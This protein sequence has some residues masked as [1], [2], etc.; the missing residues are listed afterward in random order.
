MV[1]KAKGLATRE[2]I[3]ATGASLIRQYG[4]DAVTVDQITQASGVSKG[5]FYLYFE[6]KEE[7]FYRTGATTL[8]IA[9]KALQASSDQHVTAALRAYAEQW[10]NSHASL[11]VP[12]IE[13]WLGLLSNAEARKRFASATDSE[14]AVDLDERHFNALVTRISAAVEAGEIAPSIPVKIIAH[15]LLSALYGSTVRYCMTQGQEDPQRWIDAFMQS[16]TALLN[17]VERDAA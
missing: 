2:K 17:P 9:D 10:W 12:Y 5:T 6:S 13:H 1:L 7:L 16:A 14:D 4:Y 11:G 3:A 8:D 15:N